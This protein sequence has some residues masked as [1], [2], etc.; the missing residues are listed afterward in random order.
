MAKTYAEY[1]KAIGLRESNGNYNA[2]NSI[3]Y[4]GK[5]Q[6]GELALI[7]L[8]YYTKDG[9][10]KLDFLSEF[11]TGKDGIQSKQDFL[12][13][14]AVQE[15][16]MK[17]NLA[18]NFNVLKYLG[19]LDYD[20]QVINGIRITV[21]G[22]LA[23]SHLVGAGGLSKFLNSGGVSAAGD[24]FGTTATE[25]V[26]KFGGYDIPF[27]PVL[28]AITV[29]GGKG[30][31]ILKGGTF[32]DTL[33]GGAGGKDKLV[34]GRGDDTYVVASA[35]QQIVE[36]VNGGKDT[37]IIT[38]AGSFDFANVET[39]RFAKALTGPVTI[40]GDSLDNAVLSK[41][42]DDVTFDFSNFTGTQAFK[43]IEVDLKGGTDR[44][45]FLFDME[46]H[47]TKIN[48][49]IGGI[50]ADDRIDV[51]SL[52]LLGFVPEQGTSGLKRGLYLKEYASTQHDG[53]TGFAVVS[54][55]GGQP[56][57]LD[58]WAFEGEALTSGHFII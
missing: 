58:Q 15:K 20:G 18:F 3:G 14:P 36:K 38:K 44:I 48:A 2:V 47:P 12:S 6:F 40:Q 9:T 55:N 23:G 30:N 31:D 22:M 52:G 13:S 53:A 51:S 54:V 7:T 45:E 21:S 43:F 19:D 24:Q 41:G 37:A 46:A 5:Y 39:I 26:T 17:A 4:L 27:K 32:A 56:V 25:Y 33:D 29:K 35:P 8:G 1:L 50:D 57:K 49:Y 11:F 34:G 10:G 42:D 28:T 16:V